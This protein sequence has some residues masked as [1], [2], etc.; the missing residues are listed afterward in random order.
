MAQKKITPYRHLPT[1]LSDTLDGSNVN[2]GAMA[3]LANLIFDVTT[4]NTFQCRPASVPVTT[5]SGFS[6]PTTVSIAYT[7]GQYVYGMISSGLNAGHDQPFGYDL[8]NEVFLA[9][10]GT[11]SAATTPATQLTTGDWTPPTMSLMGPLLVVTHPGFTGGVNPAFGWF[12]ITTPNAPVWH[13][14]NTTGN[15]LPG[16]P[17]CSVQFNNRIYLG[18]GNDIYFTDTLAL[19]MTLSSQYTTFGDTNPVVALAP[20]PLF[21]VSQGGVIQSILAFKNTAIL[22]ITGDTSGANTFATNVLSSEVGTRSPR[23]IA[24]TPYGVAFAAVDGIRIVQQTGQVSNPDGNLRVPF[25]F[26]INP[27]RA[28]AGYNNGIY[29]ICVQNGNVTG[30]PYQEYWYDSLRGNWTGPHSFRQDLVVPYLDTFVLFNGAVVG[31]LFT[32]DVVQSEVSTF[33]ENSSELMWVYLPA[34]MPDTDEMYQT[35][36]VLTTVDMILPTDGSTYSCSAID[37]VGGTLNTTSIQAM[38]SGVLWG[39]FTWGFAL[40][41]SF[42]AVL[43][44]YIIPWTIPLV[45]NRIQIQVTGNSSLNLKIGK[46]TIGYRVLNYIRYP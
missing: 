18:I 35:E 17:T 39:F 32:S 44:S 43:R 31:T 24:A 41:S 9:V 25:L 42:M 5:F 7:V 14:G 10:S 12:D 37:T 1:G 23:S 3:S 13:A 4:P 38:S 15:A 6:T 11:V 29:R 26:V 34:P 20:V 8:V 28:S 22:Q 16:V 36:A 19:N 21:S 46:M 45:F 27:T 40:W 2:P 33:T 30:Q